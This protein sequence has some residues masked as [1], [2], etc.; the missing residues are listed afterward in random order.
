MAAVKRFSS[1]SQ[2]VN[3]LEMWFWELNHHVEGE[4]IQRCQN[5]SAIFIHKRI[6]LK[7][8]VF[9]N[10]LQVIRHERSSKLVSIKNQ[11]GPDDRN[12]FN[13]LGNQG[14]FTC[15]HHYLRHQF[16]SC[17]LCPHRSDTHCNTGKDR[18]RMSYL[19]SKNIWQKYSLLNW[20][21]TISMMAIEA[22]RAS[23]VVGFSWPS[24]SLW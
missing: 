15:H 17:S 23:V 7:F 2:F 24:D 18:C 11:H 20:Q 16:H 9:L 22:G 14:V 4:G 12:W 21:L 6:L 1:I 19:F 13:L 3:N 8:S 5:K 10:V